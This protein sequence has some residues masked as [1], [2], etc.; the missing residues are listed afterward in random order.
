MNTDPQSTITTPYPDMRSH[1]VVSGH[2]NGG[3]PE[4]HRARGVLIAIGV[5]LGVSIIG[6]AVF[7]FLIRQEPQ[8]PDETLQSLRATSAPV[9]A[10]STERLLEIKE[11]KQ[12]FPKPGSVQPKP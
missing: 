4:Q 10:T 12:R 7:Y 11:V 9:T 2:M 3:I 6:F 8:T 1:D 5:I